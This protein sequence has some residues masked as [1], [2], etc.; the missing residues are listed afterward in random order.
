MCMLDTCVH[1]TIRN[2][3]ILKFQLHTVFLHHR[4]LKIHLKLVSIES[5]L[6]NKI[7]IK[8]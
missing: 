1:G 3:K 5:K 4:V 8:H 7:T 6:L 2:R